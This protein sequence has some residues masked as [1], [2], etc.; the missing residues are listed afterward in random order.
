MAEDSIRARQ[1]MMTQDL[2]HLGYDLNDIDKYLAKINPEEWAYI[3]HDKD[4][5]ESGESIRPHVHVVLK[6]KNPQTLDRVAS[7]LKIEPQYL[8]VWSGR[9]NNAQARTA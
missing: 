4:I 9:I 5:N 1:F 3:L 8:E 7:D 2:N 6:F